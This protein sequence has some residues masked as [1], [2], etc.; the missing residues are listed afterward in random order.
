M[1]RLNWHLHLLEFSNLEIMLGEIN[2]S[3]Y[4]SYRVFIS[5]RLR[6]L[7]WSIEC[8]TLSSRV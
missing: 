4:L 6:R 2:R 8:N 7:L 1:L 3:I 5:L